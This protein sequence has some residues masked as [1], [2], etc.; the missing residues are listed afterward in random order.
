MLGLDRF[1]DSAI[2]IKMRVKTDVG[3]QWA[4][5]REMNRRIKKRFDKEGIEIPFPH[6]TVFLA[7]SSRTPPLLL[8]DTARAELRQIIREEIANAATR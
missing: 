8:D 7:D 2:V 1:E 6:R 4:V 3:K 5:G